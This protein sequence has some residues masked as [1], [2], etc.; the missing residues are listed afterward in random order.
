MDRLKKIGKI[1]PKNSKDIKNSK[2][3]LGFEKLDRAVFDPQK[4][5]DPV[6]AAGVKWARIQSGWQ[7]TERK[8][9]V[10][11]F[12]WLDDII[13]NLMERGIQPWICLC[14]GNDLYSPQAKE[15]FGAVG[16]PPI[17]TEEEKSAWN[18]Y[19]TAIVK[20]YKG[21]IKHYEVW[22]EPDGKWCWKHGINATELGRFTI[23]TAK[24]VKAADENAEVIGG[25][26][27]H[28]ELCFMNE[29]FKT[30]MGDYIDYVSFHEYTSD[31]T[32]VFDRVT[33]NKSLARMY[34][35]KLKMIQGESGSQSKRG[36]HGAVRDLAWTPQR[37]AKQLARHT[38]ADLI[39]DVELTSYFS[40]LDMIEA[41]NGTSGDVASYQDYGYFGVLAA[42][43]DEQGNSVGT[44]TEKPSYYA[45]QCISA[46]FCDNCRHTE[47]PVIFMP[48]YS[49]S[50]LEKDCEP[51]ET[52]SGGFEKDGTY[53]FVYWKPQN[54]LTSDYL[55][56][57]TLEASCLGD[58]IYLVDIMDGSVYEIP[59]TIMSKD[60]IGNVKF[61]HLPI[62]DTPMVLI[63]GT[64]K[65]CFSEFS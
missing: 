29:A 58:E 48:E 44:Y 31:E 46:M 38:I 65:K 8:K 45:L 53:A 25:V 17:F 47:L 51:F 64:N 32:Q 19:V 55:G 61:S 15:V 14:Y 49:P 52:V 23:D 62:K 11:N 27:C 63:F 43:F 4:A 22:N 2:I 1:I 35:P 54:I 13:E 9:G 56:T 28:H 5:Y 34:N 41:L 50:I 10:Y 33:A 6:A 16:C 7:R 30:G 26:I 3:G 42:D 39:S 20:H 59:E 40:T 37:Q 57:V 21:R 18:A 12:A 36:G 24:T 60:D